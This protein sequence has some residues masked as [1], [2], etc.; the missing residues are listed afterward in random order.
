MKKL[1]WNN[2]NIKKFWDYQSQNSKECFFTYQFGSAIS[3]IVKIK[4][5]DK[6]LDYGC[7][8]G[9]LIQHLIKKS[10]AITGMD[11][12]PE[13][14]ESVR[15][16]YKNNSSFNKCFTY[17][18]ILEDGGT[19]DVIFVIEVIE[20]LTDKFLDDLFENLKK[21]THSGSKII[22]TTPNDENLDA[23]IVYC[24]QCDQT[25]HRWQHLRKW[26]IGSLSAFLTSK[27]FHKHEAFTINFD[28]KNMNFIKS[29]FN[30]LLTKF[31]LRKN[32]HLV[33]VVTV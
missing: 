27:G 15:V 31:K 32:P 17:D 28:A 30:F 18:E 11:F 1:E 7:G 23:N 22:I 8:S 12:A 24:P 9:D 19:Y 16:R 21:F 14:V 26:S 13:T 10:N 5:S 6:V 4:L 25:F 29:L 20:H 33:A 3:D 2:Y